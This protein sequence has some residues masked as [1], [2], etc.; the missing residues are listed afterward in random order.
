MEALFAL[1][2]I[3]IQGKKR[4]KKLGFP[5]ANIKPN[6]DIPEGIYASAVI[7]DNKKYIAAT[8]I[9]AAKTFNEKEKW[10]ES[11]LLDFDKDI[12]GKEITI[13]LYNK[14][15]DNIKFPSEDELV[16]QIRIDVENVKKYFN[17]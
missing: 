2:G 8:F 3:V 1:T 15:R 14:L 17:N 10:V 4:G 7:V 12:Y 6:N 13:K 11:Y 16:E 5:T 9:G